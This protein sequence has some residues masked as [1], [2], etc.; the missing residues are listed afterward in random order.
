MEPYSVFNQAHKFLNFAKICQ[1]QPKG[2]K[3]WNNGAQTHT[4]KTSPPNPSPQRK[5]VQN[6]LKI[7]F[8]NI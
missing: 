6:L 8:I 7:K 1:N 5:K 4:Q 2:L 3:D